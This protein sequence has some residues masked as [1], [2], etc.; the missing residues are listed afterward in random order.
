[1][2][3]LFAV[4]AV[5]VSQVSWAVREADLPQTFSTQVMDYYR[6]ELK[7]PEAADSPKAV[8]GFINS[9]IDGKAL[10]YI[11]FERPASQEKGKIVL[12]T[13]QGEFALRYAELF[14]DLKN[15]GYSIYS[16]DHRGQG[17]S[18]DPA[19]DIGLL[20]D[21]SYYVQDLRQFFDEVVKAT[22]KKPAYIL[23]HSMG[24]AISALFAHANPQLVKKVALSAPMMRINLGKYLNLLPDAFNIQNNFAEAFLL[25]KIEL[26]K[27]NEPMKSTSKHDTLEDDTETSSLNRWSIYREQLAT[28]P[29]LFIKAPSVCWVAKAIDATKKVVKLAP[30]QK[31]PFLIM[32]AGADQLVLP[33]GQ[34]EF[35]ARMNKYGQSGAKCRLVKAGFETSKHGILKEQ[36]GIRNLAI[37]LVLE[38]FAAP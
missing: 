29:E 7:G 2:K 27:C 35:C 26:G 30:G 9:K 34:N 31:V 17:Q 32:Q 21:F 23:G 13:G 28:R 18:K 14:Y 20:E 24:G 37:G 3:L 8:E 12:V 11:K 1:M 5:L 19:I 33:E 25:G 16:I 38:F 36:D 10:H 4:S 15:S 6:G 22:T